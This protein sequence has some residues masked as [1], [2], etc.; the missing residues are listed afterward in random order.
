MP[1][2]T[3]IWGIPMFSVYLIDKACHNSK[4]QCRL[5]CCSLPIYRLVKICGQPQQA[6]VSTSH[7]GSAQLLWSKIWRNEQHSCEVREWESDGGERRIEGREQRSQR[8]EEKELIWNDFFEMRV[9]ARY[10]FCLFFGE[11]TIN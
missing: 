1:S 7:N 3:V 9:D 6:F 8:R 4:N 5:E 2:S 11:I 10:W